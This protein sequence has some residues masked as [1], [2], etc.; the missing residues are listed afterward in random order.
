M[1]HPS[2]HLVAKVVNKTRIY[3]K[4]PDGA[5]RPILWFK[6]HKE[7]E[8]LW[9]PY[10]LKSKQCVLHSFSPDEL[11]SENDVSSRE[12]PFRDF[13]E[14]S[15]PIDHFMSHTDGTFHLKGKHAK[16]LYSHTMRMIKRL[17]VNS[18]KF[19]EFM[20]ATEV[21]TSY[22]TK[23]KVNDA[24]PVIINTENSAGVEIYGMIAGRN[25]DVE[26]NMNEIL[27]NSW[28]NSQVFNIG[29]F[30]AAIA[31]MSIWPDIELIEDRHK[32]T[33]VTLRFYLINKMYHHKTFLFD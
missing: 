10:S 31:T 14:V 8:I 28:Q 20:V 11:V 32:G 21:A 18:P 16:P 1:S 30:K 26:G 23:S 5:L 6:C 15:E 22:R 7:N 19:L 17:N 9:S 25:F 29:N 4:T 2:S 3:L 12:Y 27:N 13:I 33:L 24:S